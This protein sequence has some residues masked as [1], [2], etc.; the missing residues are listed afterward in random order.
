M[1]RV[2]QI[3]TILLA[4]LLTAC[5]QPSGNREKASI[6]PTRTPVSVRLD[7]SPNALHAPIYAALAEGYFAAEGLDVKVN[8]ATDKDDVLKLVDS[9]VDTIGL[10]YQSS[11]L[12]SQAKGYDLKAFGA[13]VQ[14]PLNVLLVDKRAGLSSLKDL[15][16]K[17]IGF[18]SDP[19]PKGALSTSAA[20]VKQMVETAGG[21]WSKIELVDVGEAA[22]QALATR[23]VD[24][25]AG[26]YEYH[27]RYLLSKEGV[28]TDV[29]RLNEHG[30]PDF[31]ELVWVTNAKVAKEQPELLQKFLRAVSKGAAATTKNP[32]KAAQE[33]LQAASTLKPAYVEATVPVVV[34]YLNDGDAVGSMSRERWQKVADW[35][36]A[37]GALKE[38]PDLDRLLLMK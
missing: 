38:K 5:S 17:K 33:L 14:H 1:K 20:A 36:L 34:P 37:Q 12:K 7:W 16:G 29:F 25:L 18:T 24:A 35:L 27:E 21:D 30:A 26:V 2:I 15:T 31:Y 11:V 9:G 19:M 28:E 10:Y 6:K 13:Y 3:L 22:V 32:N 8:P 23:K 4:V